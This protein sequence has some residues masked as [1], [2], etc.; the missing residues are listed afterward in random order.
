MPILAP[1]RR[2]GKPKPSESLTV[3]LVTHLGHFVPFPCESS[4][5]SDVRG[6]CSSS[7]SRLSAFIEYL[8]EMQSIIAQSK[9]SECVGLLSLHLLDLCE[10]E[11]NALIDE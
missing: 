8:R 2:S 6:S 5:L 10:G 1:C 3:S 7:S 9:P 11:G 4:V